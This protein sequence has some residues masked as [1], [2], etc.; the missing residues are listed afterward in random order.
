M[1]PI[2]KSQKL[3][4]INFNYA[5]KI[6]ERFFVLQNNNNSF[7]TSLAIVNNMQLKQFIKELFDIIGTFIGNFSNVTPCQLLPV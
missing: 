3:T 1:K 5:R 4:E 6:T 2:N 7:Y